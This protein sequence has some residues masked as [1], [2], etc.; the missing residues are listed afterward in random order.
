[1]PGSPP[2]FKR[3]LGS[4]VGVK[5]LTIVSLAKLGEKCFG[6]PKLKEFVKKVK[7]YYDNFFDTILIQRSYC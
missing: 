2:T 3:R 1:M 7:D 6:S 4:R 5:E